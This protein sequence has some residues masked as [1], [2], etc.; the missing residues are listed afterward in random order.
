MSSINHDKEEQQ[1]G[2]EDKGK[3]ENKRAKFEGGGG[4][5]EGRGCKR[6]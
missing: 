2:G 1:Q 3:N 5:V 6:G 4:K